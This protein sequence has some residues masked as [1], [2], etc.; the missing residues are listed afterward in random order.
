MVISLGQEGA[1]NDPELYKATWLDDGESRGKE[2][3]AGGRPDHGGGTWKFG[4]YSAD[5]WKPREGM[6]DTVLP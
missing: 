4:F 2:A 1:R 5:N 6:S 3:M